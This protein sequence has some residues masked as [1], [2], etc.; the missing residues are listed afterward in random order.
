M[1]GNQDYGDVVP[2]Y[3]VI[4]DVHLSRARLARSSDQK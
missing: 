4:S 1:E 3:E 2:Q